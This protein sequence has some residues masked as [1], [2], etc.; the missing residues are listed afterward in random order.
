MPCSS[1][2]TPPT[3]APAPSAWRVRPGVLGTLLDLI[4]I[5]AGWEPAVEAALGEA[6][7]AVVTSDP[8]A[9]AR[10]LA[11][12]RGAD[13]TGAVLA[14][15]LA[16]PSGD[17]R[18]PGG[19]P[20][21]P[22]VAADRVSVGALLDRLLATA[23]RVDDL[24]AAI[25]LAARH[26]A[27]IVVTASGD[28][29]GASGWRLGAASSGGVTAAALAEAMSRA[30]LAGRET[31]R[32][33]AEHQRAQAALSGIRRHLDELEARLEAN[34]ARMTA[35]SEAL[36]RV[37]AERRDA[38]VEL[39]ALQA[40]ADEL[41]A[42]VTAERERIVELER[43]LPDLEAGELAEADAVRSR[44]ETSLA[45]DARAAVLV[46]RRRDLEVRAAAPRGASATPARA[47]GGHR[48]ASGR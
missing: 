6:L 33:H 42:H 14:L 19:D 34:D 46:G 16:G 9:A 12:L 3:R 20:V 5:D 8:A 43:L 39:G 38:E 35:A 4:R 26:P 23:V 2:S 40:R 13:T 22:H 47:A 17:G 28:R 48:A 44:H 41:R 32:C 36:A 45:L 27:A 10:A 11:A 18:P 7:D 30:E 21:R 24:D 31:E 29:L 1:P 25:D 15:G 37:N